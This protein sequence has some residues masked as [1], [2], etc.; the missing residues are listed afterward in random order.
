REVVPPDGAHHRAAGVFTDGAVPLTGTRGECDR[1]VI[2]HAEHGFPW[3]GEGVFHGRNSATSA[4]RQDHAIPI[5]DPVGGACVVLR[6]VSSGTD[7][8][9]SC[10]GQVGSVI[11]ES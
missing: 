10:E 9:A 4:H 11:A 1:L 6:R 2:G 3:R 8:A 5:T 7:L